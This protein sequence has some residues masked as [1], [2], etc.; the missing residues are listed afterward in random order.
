MIIKASRG[1]GQWQ[2]WQ[3]DFE[4][5]FLGHGTDILVPEDDHDYW[6]DDRFPTDDVDMLIHVDDPN[7]QRAPNAAGHEGRSD[8]FVKWVKWY[9]SPNTMMIVT[10]GPVYI[11][12]D[13][14]R[15]IEALH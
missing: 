4:L 13:E 10:N 9:T 1:N 11:L 12:N 5:Q 14:G 7:G 2:L 8:V 15:T 6:D 3:A